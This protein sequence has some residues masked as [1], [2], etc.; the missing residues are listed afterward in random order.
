LGFCDQGFEEQKELK[1][2]IFSI[3]R[4][5]ERGEFP[6]PSTSMPSLL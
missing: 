6:K 3:W 5:I 1:V 4:T 2:N